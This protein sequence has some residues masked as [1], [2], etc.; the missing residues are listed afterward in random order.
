MEGNAGRSDHKTAEKGK[1]DQ[2]NEDN[3]LQKKKK[4][5]KAADFNTFRTVR[6]G[7]LGRSSKVERNAGDL[8]VLKGTVS[9]AQ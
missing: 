9:K 1:G 3:G 2:E 5:K 6:H 7:L 4:K 8:V